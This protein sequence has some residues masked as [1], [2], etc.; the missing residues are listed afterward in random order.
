MSE[1]TAVHTLSWM[2]DVVVQH[3]RVDGKQ[4]IIVRDNA[5]DT[6]LNLTVLQAIA[7]HGQLDDATELHEQL[8]AVIEEAI[9][10]GY[11]SEEAIS[12]GRALYAGAKL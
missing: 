8:G 2:T 12:L 4:Q 7:F 6:T 1:S 11:A 10:A 3:W 9:T 5:T